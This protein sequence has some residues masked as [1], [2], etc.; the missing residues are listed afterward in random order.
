[1]P[2]SSNHG[3][4]TYYE[5]VG[6][7]PAIVMLH[8]NGTDHQLFL[9]QMAHFAAWF[10]VIAPDLRGWGRTATGDLPYSL[11]DLADDVVGICDQEGVSQGIFLGVS[12][13][14]RLTLHIGAKHPDL[15][16]ALIVVGG[17][18]SPSARGADQAR[19]YREDPAAQRRHL[20]TLV[21]ERFS[22]SPL[23]SKLLDDILAR[24][25]RFGRTAADGART[26]E[27]GSGSDIG[28]GLSRI[29]APTL[30]INGEFDHSRPRG[31]ETARLVP[32]A[33]HVVLKGAGHCCNIEDPM[34]FDAVVIDFLR[35]Q[36][37]MPTR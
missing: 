13:G 33:R 6:H 20:M 12:I 14:S 22:G 21:S 31:E 18:H 10:R 1:L 28:A 30:V 26:M 32:G 7:G 5:V 8:A 23:G 29:R 4:K 16:R 9:Y 37:L 27:A 25:V 15:A 34:T 11:G 24:A 19:R 3:A 36:G 17:G 35:E 2:Y